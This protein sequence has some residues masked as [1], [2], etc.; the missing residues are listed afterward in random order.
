M[1]L[2]ISTPPNAIAYASGAIKTRDM[3]VA[4]SLI[5][6]VGMVVLVLLLPILIRWSGVQ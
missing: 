4:G 2:P 6:I 3:A 1:A 5:G